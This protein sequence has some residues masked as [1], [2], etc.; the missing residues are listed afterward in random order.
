VLRWLRKGRDGPAPADDTPEPSVRD[1]LLSLLPSDTFARWADSGY[2]AQVLPD[3][4]A[5]RRVSQLPAHRDNAFIHTMK[6]V[7]A[8]EPQL[9]RRWAA[10]MHDIGKAP[11]YIETPGGRTHFFE[12]DS[13]GADMAGEIMAAQ[14][15]E[16]ATID[17]V[18]CLVRLHMRPISYR[19]D[20]TDSAVKRLIEEAEESRGRPGWDDLIA[21]SRADLRGYLPEPIDRGLWVLQSLEERRRSIEEAERREAAQEEA[22]PHSP[23][24]GN[25][26]LALTDCDPGPWIAQLKDYL[27]QQV[28]TGHLA[29]DDKTKA[30]ELALKWM[31][32]RG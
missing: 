10:L 13:I 24:D 11:T 25:E 19:P 23:L 17:A 9:I 28:A 14:G 22:E 4:D 8:I 29:Q 2:L 26:I 30:R 21:L 7:D 15:E 18:Q 1:V 6:V 16:Q 5:L 12:H 27:C 20:W 31:E 32:E 3:V